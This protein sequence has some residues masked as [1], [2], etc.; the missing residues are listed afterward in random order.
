MSIEDTR[1]QLHQLLWSALAA[2]D[3]DV[4]ALRSA[5]RD[6]SHLSRD[7]GI[8]SLDIIEFHVRIQSVLG[9]VIQ[10]SD[11]EQAST[12]GGIL[13]LLQRPAHGHLAV[14]ES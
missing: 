10:D 2:G 7:L 9:L 3:Y 4:P 11:F 13:A 5:L 1:Q 14:G 12:I 6:D 8:E